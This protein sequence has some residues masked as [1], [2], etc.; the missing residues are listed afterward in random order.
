MPHPQTGKFCFG[1]VPELSDL[2]T[3]R[4]P[5]YLLSGFHTGGGAGRGRGFGVAH[6]QAA[7]AKE[8]KNAKCSTVAEYIALN[9]LPGV[10]LCTEGGFSQRERILAMRMKRTIVALEYRQDRNLG[11]Y[12]SIITAYVRGNMLPAQQLAVIEAC[13]D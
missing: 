9:V 1:I 13:D 2:A 4:S 5:I 7:H 8:I 3:D 11:N 10:P 6:I 12:W